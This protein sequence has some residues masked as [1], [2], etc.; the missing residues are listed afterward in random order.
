MTMDEHLQHL[1]STVILTSVIPCFTVLLL[2]A[3]IS[4]AGPVPGTWC[5]NN[6]GVARQIFG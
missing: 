4:L 6:I 3:K 1:G 5:N 2:A